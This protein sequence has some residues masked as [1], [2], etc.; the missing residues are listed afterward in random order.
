MIDEQTRLSLGQLMTRV[1]A[2]EFTLSPKELD[3]MFHQLSDPCGRGTTSVT[4]LGVSNSGISPCR[5]DAPLGGGVKLRIEIPARVEGSWSL[6]SG[7]MLKLVFA[8][9]EYAPLIHFLDAKGAPLILD[10]EFGGRIRFAESDGQRL[11]VRT[12]GGCVG[13]RAK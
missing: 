1:S 10:E 7:A 11:F 9:D 5:L 12:R 3:D 4:L 6:R 13:V 8:R 2:G